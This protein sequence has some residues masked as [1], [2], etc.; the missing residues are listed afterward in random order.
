MEQLGKEVGKPQTAQVRGCSHIHVTQAPTRT[1]SDQHTH[2]HAH[3][4]VSEHAL[5]HKVHICGTH[6]AH[7]HTHLY[8]HAHTARV[9]VHVHTR[10]HTCHVC[11]GAMYACAVERIGCVSAAERRVELSTAEGLLRSSTPWSPRPCGEQP[12]DDVGG[13]RGWR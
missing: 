10:T 5:T 8:T 6:T 12:R 3:A 7:V 4:H 1:P 9:H 11:T 2:A 13:V